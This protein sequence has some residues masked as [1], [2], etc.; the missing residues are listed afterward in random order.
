MATMQK[1]GVCH[2]TGN[3]PVLS[4]RTAL[5]KIKIDKNEAR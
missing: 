2:S 5:E 4:A 1:C 3:G